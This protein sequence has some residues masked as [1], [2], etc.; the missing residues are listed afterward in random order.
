[1][2]KPQQHR[3]APNESMVFSHITSHLNSSVATDALVTHY[4]FVNSKIVSSLK[5]HS[6]I[7]MG[8]CHWAFLKVIPFRL[9]LA[10]SFLSS[11]SPPGYKHLPRS[12]GPRLLV[13]NQRNSRGS[14]SPQCETAATE[15]PEPC[16]VLGP[17][18]GI[19]MHEALHHLSIHPEQY[20][21]RSKDGH[22]ST[23]SDPVGTALQEPCIFAKIAGREAPCIEK[24]KCHAVTSRPNTSKPG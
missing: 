11:C 7:V 2:S 14:P 15:R 5:L 13:Y 18:Q 22:S 9:F 17:D 8:A 6:R 20:A 23:L 10:S 3:A 19:P 4:F 24:L 21:E 12:S 16:T 1:M